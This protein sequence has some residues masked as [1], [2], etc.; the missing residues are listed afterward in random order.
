MKKETSGHPELH[1]LSNIAQDVEINR[2]IEN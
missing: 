2:D 1:S